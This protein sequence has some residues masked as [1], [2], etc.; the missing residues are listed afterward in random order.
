M[1]RLTLLPLAM[2]LLLSQAAQAAAPACPSAKFPLFLA[3]YADSVAVQKA[4]TDDPLALVMLDHAAEPEPRQVKSQLAKARL[5]FPLLPPAAV[6]KKHGLALRIDEAT[7]KQARATLFKEDTGYLVTYF[8][9]KDGCWKLE[10]KE[11]MSM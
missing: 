9:R 4:F 11:D 5:S 7:D 8:F 10:R 3:K 2:G 1:K 6:R